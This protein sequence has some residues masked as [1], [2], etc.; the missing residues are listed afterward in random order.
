MDNF[1]DILRD[2]VNE[3]GLSLRKLEKESGISSNQYSRYLRGA[4]PA[5]DCAIK[6][7]NY[8]NCSLD[9]LFGLTDKRNYT[10]YS[11]ILGDWS[12]FLGRYKKLLENN[13]ITHWKFCKN[14]GLSESN[15][16]HWENYGEHPNIATLFVISFNL[17]DSI[18]FLVGR[19]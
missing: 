15:I 16:R 8:F 1:V 12:V 9:Y 7:A 19:L 5:V 11:N 4:M 6:M 14:N 2:L 18:D 3:K 17:G 10:N 13:K